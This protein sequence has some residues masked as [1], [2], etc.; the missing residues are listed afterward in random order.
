MKPEGG[1]LAGHREYGRG[2][3]PPSLNSAPPCVRAGRNETAAAGEGVDVRGR[4]GLLVFIVFSVPA[5]PFLPV[6]AVW[7]RPRWRCGDTS[8][9]Q[10]VKRAMAN[11]RC[12]RNSCRWPTYSS[13]SEPSTLSHPNRRVNVSLI[14]KN[15]PR[16]DKDN[17]YTIIK[18]AG[19]NERAI[20]RPENP[21]RRAAP[22]PSIHQFVPV[23][24]KEENVRKAL[25]TLPFRLPPS[26][27]QLRF[28]PRVRARKRHRCG[29]SRA[30]PSGRGRS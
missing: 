30:R 28:T 24:V 29:G 27:F 21:L 13:D 23:P 6:S 17:V 25:H 26:K 22:D 2:S 3:R 14:A 8:A 19:H 12:R 7:E 1:R 16:I 11:S 4:R 15:W 9:T 10:S 5:P 20:S 18:H